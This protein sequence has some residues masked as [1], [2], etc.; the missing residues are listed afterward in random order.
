MQ[1][2][3]SECPQR[4]VNNVPE[5]TFHSFTVLSNPATTKCLP[6]GKNVRD[7]TRLLLD[8]SC[9]IGRLVSATSHT[10]T[11]SAI[12]PVAKVLPSGENATTTHA[13]L[14]IGNK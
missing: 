1:L 14:G 9:T 3:Q 7:E 6:S 10:F 5:F 2:T 8:V 12:S 11:V 4:V 13:N